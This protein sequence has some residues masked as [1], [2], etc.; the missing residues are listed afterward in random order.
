MK[1]RARLAARIFFGLSALL[2]AGLGCAAGLGLLGVGRSSHLV[3][4]AVVRPALLIGGLL[5]AVGLDLGKLVFTVQDGWPILSP[6]GVFL[7]YFVP[8]AA[9]G[10]LA[11]RVGGSAHDNNNGATQ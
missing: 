8:A 2:W 3:V 10:V 6:F 7:V 9:L 11:L 5:G 4:Q 1:Q